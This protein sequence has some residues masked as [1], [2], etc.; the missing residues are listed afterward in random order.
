MV[1]RIH[2]QNVALRGSMKRA[3]AEEPEADPAVLGPDRVVEAV[4]LILHARQS[5]KALRHP[6][7]L[8]AAATGA[9]VDNPQLPEQE[10]PRRVQF[11]SALR[12]GQG[13]S[14]QAPQEEFVGRRKTAGAKNRRPS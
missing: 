12:V 11:S 8:P 9:D 14:Q 7:V 2:W 13:E 6:V 4:V 5:P 3:L 1:G 10:M